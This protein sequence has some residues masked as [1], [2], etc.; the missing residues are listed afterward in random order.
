VGIDSLILSQVVRKLD[1][2]PDCKVA[3]RLFLDLFAV[4]CLDPC[5]V[6]VTEDTG[7][8]VEKVAYIATG[9]GKIQQTR[10]GEVRESVSQDERIV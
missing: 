2:V 8:L 3:L 7:G 1:I 6:E 4:R 10:D 5:E 9:C